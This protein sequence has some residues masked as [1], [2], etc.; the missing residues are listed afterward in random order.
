MA[1]MTNCP[2]APIFQ[3]LDL[4]QTDKPKAINSNGVALTSNSDKAYTLL[5]GSQKN[6]DKPLVGEMPMPVNKA[7]PNAHVIAKASKG[8]A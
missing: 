2:S 4:K 8:E 5:I 1:P 7:D 6:M 3:I